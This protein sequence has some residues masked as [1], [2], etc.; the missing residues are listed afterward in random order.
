MALYDNLFEPIQVGSITIKNRIVRS[1]HG[2]GLSGEPLIAYHEARARGGV[3]M[4]TIEATGVDPTAPIGIAP[5]RPTIIV[6][7]CSNARRFTISNIAAMR[8]TSRS[9][10][11]LRILPWAVS[12]T[13]ELVSP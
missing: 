11:S 8:F 13:S 4:S 9:P 12:S 1:P 3:G 10:T 6:S 2:T 5:R 7:R